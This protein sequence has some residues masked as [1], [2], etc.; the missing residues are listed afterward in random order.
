MEISFDSNG[1]W[2]PTTTGITQTLT[3]GKYYIFLGGPY[4]TSIYQLC[5]NTNNPVYYYDGTNLIDANL[6]RG[7][8]SVTVSGTGNAVTTASLSNGNLT[9]EKGTTFLH[10]GNT[11]YTPSVTSGTKLGTITIDG[12]STDVYSTGKLDSPVNIELGTGV[13]STAT[14]FDGSEN[15]TI[16]VTAIKEAYLEW[17]GKDFSGSFGP[18]DAALNPRL[19]ANRMEMT[20]AAGITIER[21][22]DSGSTWTTL[23]VSDTNK[24]AFMSSIG[25]SIAVSGTS[26][27][28]LGTDA[29]KNIM[30][31]TID[32]VAGSI[33]TYLR[34]FIIYL[35]TGGCTGCYVKIRIRTQTDFLAGNDTWKTWDC[36]NR[37]WSS[38]VTESNSRCP[39]SGWSGFNVI[40]VIGFTAFRNKD[41]PSHSRNI[42]FIFGCKT[43]ASTSTGMSIISIQG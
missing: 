39:V 24:Q 11:S 37:N 4:N 6:I 5:L 34:K 27:A 23:N 22:T 13:L 41:M 16:P 31:V 38:S 3:S 25:Y 30:R 28:N 35:S 29:A 7:V 2:S 20:K 10:A 12:T 21:S 18:F 17:G 9:L 14:A 26:T 32:T 36:V 15:I 19:G 1:L 42:Q 33:Y 40:N 43:N 8:K